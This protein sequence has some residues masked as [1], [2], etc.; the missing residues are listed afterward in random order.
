MSFW[1][2]LEALS[3]HRPGAFTGFKMRDLLEKDM[4]ER[5]PQTWSGKRGTSAHLKANPMDQRFG[6]SGRPMMTNWY[7]GQGQQSL[8]R[9]TPVAPVPSLYPRQQGITG[10]QGQARVQTRPLPNRPRP[11]GQPI[12]AS[13][14]PMMDRTTVR[15]I[16]A[17]PTVPDTITE[18]TKQQIPVNPTNTL[19]NMGS[20]PMLN[21]NYMMNRYRNLMLRR[22]RGN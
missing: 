2:G 10:V 17:D 11:V 4:W 22:L 12:T 8:V 19:M 1:T 13:D 18:T 9:Q 6:M 16:V 20:N 7:T 15:K 21:N 5:L 3:G 14:T